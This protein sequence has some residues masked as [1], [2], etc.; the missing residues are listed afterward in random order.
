MVT[1]GRIGLARYNRTAAVG[2]R[3][4]CA[5]EIAGSTTAAVIRIGCEIC[6]TTVGRVAIA[7]GIAR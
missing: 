5:I 6:L 1:I 2:A 7:I 4:R 3:C